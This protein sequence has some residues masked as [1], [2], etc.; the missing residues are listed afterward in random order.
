MQKENAGLLVEN[1]HK[2]VL[3]RALNVVFFISSGL[4]LSLLTCHK[5]FYWLF[6]VASSSTKNTHWASRVPHFGDSVK[7]PTGLLGSP[8]YQ[9]PDLC[10]VPQ[11]G[12]GSQA[13]LLLL[14]LSCCPTALQ[15]GDP[16]GVVTPMNQ[17]ILNGYI[18]IK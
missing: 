13:R 5:D 6:F 3:L 14:P 8:S 9:M 16:E 12:V 2:K 7:Q 15:A 11:W 1:T 18:E 17:S 4:S 10:A